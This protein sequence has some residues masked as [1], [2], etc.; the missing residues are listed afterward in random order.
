MYNTVCMNCL[1]V[2]QKAVTFQF[3]NSGPVLHEGV[4]PSLLH[5]P[6]LPV[7]QA[8]DITGPLGASHLKTKWTNWINRP[9]IGSEKI[10]FNGEFVGFVF[11]CLL[12]QI[13]SCFF[14]NIKYCP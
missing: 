1:Q 8:T 3:A 6:K 12:L 14:V 4:G 9:E 10:Y 5:H 2:G 11:I 7:S 13:Y